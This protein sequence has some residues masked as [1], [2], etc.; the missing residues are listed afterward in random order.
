MNKKYTE[1]QYA[2]KKIFNT[3]NRHPVHTWSNYR[4]S[5]QTDAG[6]S[7]HRLLIER[8]MVQPPLKTCFGG[9]GVCVCMYMYYVCESTFG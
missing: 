4:K 3:I 5:P 6:E 2:H 1:G 8:E 9:G 7:E